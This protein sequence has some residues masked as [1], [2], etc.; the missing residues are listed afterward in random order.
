MN[1]KP[2]EIMNMIISKDKTKSKLASYLHGCVYNPLLSTFQLAIRKGNFL[3]WHRIE[4]INFE[5][6]IKDTT[7]IDKG[8][9]DQ[10]RQNLQSTNISAPKEVI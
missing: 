3:S 2:Q 5:R 10:E 8:H 6:M 1:L 9:L 7:V 4:K